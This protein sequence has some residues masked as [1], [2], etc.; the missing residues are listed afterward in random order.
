MKTKLLTAAAV[1]LIIAGCTSNKTAE[2][3]TTTSTTTTVAVSGTEKFFQAV[4][5][6]YPQLINNNGRAWVIQ[7]GETACG[8]IDEGMSLTDLLNM[9]G[10]ETDGAMVGYIIRHAILNM[11]P[12]NQW[13]LDAAASA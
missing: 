2:T 13:F 11:C 6:E 4:I 3:T 7:F 8:A 9:I 1:L 10:A 12:H 5:D